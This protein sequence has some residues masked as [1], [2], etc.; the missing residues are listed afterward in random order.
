VG[1]LLGIVA[2][3]VTALVSR[4]TP[5]YAA[6]DVVSVCNNSGSSGSLSNVLASATA[7]DT[8][9]FSCSGTIAMGGSADL[10][11]KNITIDGGNAIT[12]DGG[13]ASQIF[14]VSGLVTVTL[15]NLV[16]QNGSSG[17]LGGAVEVKDG[18]TL[19]VNHVTFLNDTAGGNGGGIS[20]GGV[21]KVTNSTFAGNT[22]GA[23]GGAI[24][25]NYGLNPPSPAATLTGD[26]FSGNKADFGGSVSFGTNNPASIVNS[27]FSG[28]SA[29][30]DAAAIYT[31][32]PVSLSYSTVA[33]NISST[34]GTVSAIARNG[35]PAVTVTASILDNASNCASGASDGGSN[36]TYL[37]GACGLT[38]PVQADPQL[39]TLANN[40]GP[41]QT[42]A[43]QTGSPA[44]DAAACQTAVATDQRGVARPQGAACDIGAYEFSCGQFPE[45]GTG[46]VPGDTC[47]AR[48]G[49][50]SVTSGAS[51]VL[52]LTD[53]TQNEVS[54]AYYTRPVSL[55][56][57]FS[58]QFQFNIA[59]AADGIAF[60]I[61]SD[62]RGASALACAGGFLGISAGYLCNSSSVTP[63]VAIEFDPWFNNGFDPSC[64]Q[65]V[66]VDVNGDV[67]SNATNSTTCVTVNNGAK[68]A[69]VDYDGTAHALNLYL[70]ASGATKPSTPTL[71]FS[72][73]LSTTVGH[74]GYIGFSGATGDATATQDIQSWTTNFS[75]PAAPAF[76]PGQ[77]GASTWAGTSANPLAISGSGVPNTTVTLYGNGSCTGSAIG[78]T[79]T[80]ASGSWSIPVT[81]VAP[82]VNA[83]AATTTD[84][85]GGLSNCSSAITVN[86][87][88][89]APTSAVTFPTLGTSSA[90]LNASGWTG[91]CGTNVDDIC[92]T[93][94]DNLGGSGIAAVYVAIE[95][96][97]GTFWNGT[98]FTSSG[99]WLPA[100]L[101]N[102]GGSTSWSLAVPRPSDGEYTIASAAIDNAGNSEQIFQQSVAGICNAGGGGGQLSINGG[103]LSI[104]G[105]LC[106]ISGLQG[107]PPV[108]VSGQLSINGGQLSINGG[109]FS[110]TGGQLS[111]NG[112]QLSLNGGNGGNCTLTDNTGNSATYALK[113][114]NPPPP[115]ASPV[116]FTL[117]SSGGQLSLNGGQL[118]INGGQLSINGGQL[119]SGGGQLSLNGGQLSINGGTCTVSDTTGHSGQ[120]SI[121]GGQLSLNGGQ[122]S[123]NGGQL[124]ING[125]QLSINGGQLSL[126]G[127]Q[128][129][130]NG[131]AGGNR[132]NVVVDTVPPI[133]SFFEVDGQQGDGAANIDPLATFHIHFDESMASSSVNGTTVSVTPAPTLAPALDSLDSTNLNASFS[134]FQPK[135]YY[136]VT[137]SGATDK[138]GN[139]LIGTSANPAT[140]HFTTGAGSLVKGS[141]SANDND[142]DGI[143]NAWDGTTSPTFSLTTPAGTQTTN[144]AAWGFNPQ[145]Q[146]LCLVENYMSGGVANGTLY[147]QHISQAANQAIVSAFANAPTTNPDG[148]HGIQLV[149]FE[150]LSYSAGLPAGYA[151]P[152]FGGSIPMVEPLGTTNGSG[153]N[154]SRA[155][156]GTS[157]SF[158]DIR[159]ANFVPTGLTQFCHYAVIAHTLGGT[160]SS[161]ASRGIGASELVIALGGTTRGLGVGT[162]Q[163]QQGTVMHELGHNLG[164]HHGGGPGISDMDVNYKPDYMS[165]MNYFYQF[166]G[167]PGGFTT[168]GLDYSHGT[169]T[170]P[171]N[172]SALNDSAGLGPGALLPTG[173]AFGTRYLCNGLPN[174]VGNATQPIN[175]SCN[176]TGPLPAGTA[177]QADVNGDGSLTAPL[178]DYND[179][180]HLNFTKGDI[181]F[182]SVPPPPISTTIDI[183]NGPGDGG[184]DSAPAIESNSVAT[185]GWT[186]FFP[187]INSDT[188]GTV[189]NAGK[190]GRTYPVKF[191]LKDSSGAFVST[192]SAVRSIT[193]SRSACTGG[194]VDPIDSATTS[195]AGLHYDSSA[196]QFVYNWATPPAGCYTLAVSLADGTTSLALF[197]LT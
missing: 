197:S 73:N 48:N 133:V 97:D 188:S 166:E 183:L 151:G 165:V 184:P 181:G 58:T 114:A 144:T 75:A 99:A 163:E 55:Q 8:I 146:D 83:Y 128:L 43:L 32:A 47:L 130:I 180:A 80:D 41:T 86:G 103:Q 10:V 93:A 61:Q 170:T 148:T 129:S 34:G 127:G 162:Q 174:I 4:T 46:F 149:I 12:L 158:D 137:V 116:P 38:G 176:S 192:L 179:W 169:I 142:S 161:G 164:L 104:N 186:G 71:S 139:Q 29:S 50:A 5:T 189:V 2:L 172:E 185:F 196:N 72:V 45:Y 26:T 141:A 123:L 1:R 68:S 70:A 154:W 138:A 67:T 124:S 136:T 51:G 28:N 56:Q 89:T 108:P 27:T 135:T 19:I 78:S 37:G 22:A 94:A 88:R 52:R 195:T 147:D 64:G 18:S 65:H 132:G 39:G 119:T 23:H 62:A 159:R 85:A 44:V 16:L 20:T 171:L 30:T 101:T 115:P 13:S 15:Q 17:G 59:G 126:N 177:V 66:G 82:G 102:S 194:T 193:Y 111:L 160:G 145:R 140:F 134:G 98:N 173:A 76:S 96:S 155:A 190:A 150:G 35:T 112:G 87:D 74:T 90:Y 57:S 117:S 109:N 182:G 14:V 143:P 175:W 40:G 191:Q 54:S 131:G 157:T 187:P 100:T 42:M 106:S 91:G 3:L 92:G 168:N 69:W 25:G 156:A 113:A 120:L 125:G 95:A 11:G 33:N 6:T 107:A 24:D 7:G 81:N 105:G 49:I 84:A 152:Y 53:G 121:N 122:L 31:Y 36:L 60:A 63:S 178:N 9:T 110:P 21:L 118:S 153:F 79:N 167:V 77:S